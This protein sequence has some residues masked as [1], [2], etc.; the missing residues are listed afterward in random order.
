MDAIVARDHGTSGSHALAAR[1]LLRRNAMMMEGAG[2]TQLHPVLV[3][4]RHGLNWTVIGGMTIARLS[5]GLPSP[6]EWRA[7]LD[8]LRP[9]TRP[10]ILWIRGRVW[11]GSAGRTELAAAIGTTSVSLVAD[12]DL[13]RGLATALR[14]LGT[15]VRTYSSSELEQLETE[16]ELPSGI[17]ERLLQQVQ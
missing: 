13:G 9:S 14:W 5:G 4:E 12:G 3:S 1:L 6:Q 7:F 10:L 2:A 15:D 8:H 16:L 17:G 11:I